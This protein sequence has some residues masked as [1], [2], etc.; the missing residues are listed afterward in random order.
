MIKWIENHMGT[1]LF[2]FLCIITVECGIYCWRMPPEFRA[3]MIPRMNKII[4]SEER[5]N[6]KIADVRAIIEK[7]LKD[8]EIGISN[9]RK[10]I[11]LLLDLRRLDAISP[12]NK[13]E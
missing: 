4:N 7:N 13:P 8:V 12:S 1:V 11:N 3:E 9:N 2:I 10:H 5:I 6:K